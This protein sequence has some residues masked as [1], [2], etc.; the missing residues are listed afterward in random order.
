MAE[1]LTRREFASM[2]A[3]GSILT[4]A[5]LAAADADKPDKK[6]GD[7]AQPAADPI[8]LIIDLVKQQYPHERLDEAALEEI[9]VDVRQHL[10]RSKVLSTF[11]LMNSQEPGFVFSAWRAD[12]PHG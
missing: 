9:R 12:R 10:G 4:G 8:D 7:Q 11:P 3:V 1:P 2:V 6:P 5:P